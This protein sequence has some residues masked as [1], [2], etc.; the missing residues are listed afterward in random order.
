MG[1]CGYY[2]NASDLHQLSGVAH[3]RVL[4]GLISQPNITTMRIYQILESREDHMKW[5][6]EN[7]DTLQS[8][9]PSS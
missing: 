1:P 6:T 7:G 8:D 3:M 5:P 2:I 9:E 4:H